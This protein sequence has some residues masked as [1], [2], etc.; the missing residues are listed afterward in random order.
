MGFV[1]KFAC[2]GQ[3]TIFFFQFR[4]SGSPQPNHFCIT[5]ISFLRSVTPPAPLRKDSVML[6]EAQNK[7]PP[8]FNTTK[9]LISLNNL[10]NINQFYVNEIMVYSYAKLME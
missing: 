2:I 7:N 5:K 1:E 10:I 6:S 4:R 3:G 8:T 9:I